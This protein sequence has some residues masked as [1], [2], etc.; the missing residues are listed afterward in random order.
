[1]VAPAADASERIVYRASDGFIWSANDDGSALTRVA[2]CYCTNP[3]LSPTGDL[4]VYDEGYTEIW[5]RDADGSNPTR[6]YGGSGQPQG[7]N[8]KFTPSGRAIVFTSRA[9][10]ATTSTSSTA[11]ARTSTR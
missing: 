4:V 7:Y 1:V 9:R 2:D 5:L 11:T 10:P 8:P 3:A 6:I